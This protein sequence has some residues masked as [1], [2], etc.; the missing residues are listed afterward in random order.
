[1]LLH[2]SPFEIGIKKNNIPTPKAILSFKKFDFSHKY[3]LVV[4]YKYP[5]NLDR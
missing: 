5:R 2:R 4:D 1:M 3:I